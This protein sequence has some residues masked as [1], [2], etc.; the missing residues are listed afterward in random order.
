LPRRN[1]HLGQRIPSLRRHIYLGRRIVAPTYQIFGRHILI[2]AP[3][4]LPSAPQG[5]S[6]TRRNIFVWPVHPHC[7]AAISSAGRR[8]PSP[9]RPIIFG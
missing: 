2:A 5:I 9:H 4:S 8:I 6:S 3:P 1:S 7:R